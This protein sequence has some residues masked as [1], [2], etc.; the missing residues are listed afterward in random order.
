MAD[1]EVEA[2]AVWKP[3]TAMAKKMALLKMVTFMV[4]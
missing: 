2:E 1:S 4:D 3:R